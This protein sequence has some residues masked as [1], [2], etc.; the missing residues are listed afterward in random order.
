LLR[1]P[2]A[3]ENSGIPFHENNQ[4]IIKERFYLDKANHNTLYDDITVFDDALTRPWGK[5]EKLFRK[6]DPR[7]IWREESCP[8]DNEWLKI[9]NETYVVNEA[10]GK[11]MPAYKNQPAPDLHYFPQS[12]K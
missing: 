9:G 3:Y 12:R 7:P 1:G 8:E 11:L 4:T 10:D 6:Q 5:L 2:R